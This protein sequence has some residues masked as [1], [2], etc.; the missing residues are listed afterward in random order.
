MQLTRV[1]KFTKKLH[2]VKSE[3]SNTIEN[4]K[5]WLLL[6]D[7]TLY[8]RKRKHSSWSVRSCLTAHLSCCSSF[9]YGKRTRSEEDFKRKKYQK[10]PSQT[11]TQGDYKFLLFL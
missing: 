1:K 10:I 7:Q 3:S 11:L 6:N 9:D 2:R 4:Y 5:S 8:Q